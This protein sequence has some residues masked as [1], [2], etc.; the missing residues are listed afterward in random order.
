MR[1]DIKLKEKKRGTGRVRRSIN[2]QRRHPDLVSQ[3]WIVKG[4][5][6]FQSKPP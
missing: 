6:C 2:D 5:L 3:Q 4:L 1:P